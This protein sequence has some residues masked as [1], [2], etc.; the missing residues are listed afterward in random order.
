MNR[1]FDLPVEYLR[2]ATT[3]DARRDQSGVTRKITDGRRLKG[4]MSSERKIIEHSIERTSNK[5]CKL[6]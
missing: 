1:A 4:D 5:G 2:C 3:M 6:K